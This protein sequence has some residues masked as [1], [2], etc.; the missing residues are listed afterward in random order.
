VVTRVVVC[1]FLPRWRRWWRRRLGT[2]LPPTVVVVVV[3]VVAVVLG[4][5]VAHVPK[6]T[7]F[8]SSACSGI[9]SE[10]HVIAR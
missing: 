1:P 5:N 2:S 8:A 7:G 3:A 9:H 4:F 10:T 6:I